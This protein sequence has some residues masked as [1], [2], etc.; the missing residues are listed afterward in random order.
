MHFPTHNKILFLHDM[1]HRSTTHHSSF[2]PHPPSD[3]KNPSLL[4]SL[5]P[6]M[7]DTFVSISLSSS[8]SDS[9]DTTLVSEAA[10]WCSVHGRYLE[11]CGDKHGA[12]VA[13]CLQ[14]HREWEIDWTARWK[15]LLDSV[16][17]D[18]LCIRSIP[19]TVDE[20][21]FYAA[22]NPERP[23]TPKFFFAEEDDEFA[24]LDDDEDY[25]DLVERPLYGL[26]AEALS[27]EFL[28]TFERQAT[29]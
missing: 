27:K 6:H 21:A 25:G 10:S 5:P 2:E 12:S 7:D 3:L 11:Q 1:L 15:V 26:S 18:S 29:L 24:G 8:H 17:D 13:H 23:K 20:A 16:K 9:D 19:I 4:R 14:D 28:H 22:L